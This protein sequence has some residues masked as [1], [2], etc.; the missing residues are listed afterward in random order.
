VDSRFG[1]E[2][3]LEKKL[4]DAIQYDDEDMIFRF[5]LLGLTW[6]DDDADR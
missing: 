5:G 3:W 2:S 6:N 4:H 1:F